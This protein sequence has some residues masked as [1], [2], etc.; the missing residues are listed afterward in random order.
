MQEKLIDIL[1]RICEDEVVREDLDLDLFEAGL[2]D[3]LGFTELLVDIEDTFGIVISP[4]E[5]EREE[6]ATA[7]KILALLAERG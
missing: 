7:N 5:V 1:E 3:S 4:S 2:L 6:M